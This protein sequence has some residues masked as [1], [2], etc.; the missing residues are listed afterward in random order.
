[1]HYLFSEEEK[2]AIQECFN[3][4]KQLLINIIS[5]DPRCTQIWSNIIDGAYEKMSAN[6]STSQIVQLLFTS[7]IT[8]RSMLETLIAKKIII[9]FVHPNAPASPSIL[10]PV[11]T[12]EY[13][14]TTRSDDKVLI[15]INPMVFNKD[16]TGK[17][18]III[19]I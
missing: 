14:A 13:A 6:S 17:H 10:D 15:A 9:A 19:S 8:T 3:N 2:K 7:S 12:K 5:S 16:I 4:A 1:M 11:R 18:F